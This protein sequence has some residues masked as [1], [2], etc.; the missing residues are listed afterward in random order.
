MVWV[1]G[2]IQVY[3]VLDLI[4]AKFCPVKQTGWRPMQC[5]LLRSLVWY[6]SYQCSVD[7]VNTDL[8]GISSCFGCSHLKSTLHTVPEED[9]EPHETEGQSEFLQIHLAKLHCGLF[10]FLLLLF[11]LFGYLFVFLPSQSIKCPISKGQ[12]SKSKGLWQNCSTVVQVWLKKKKKKVVGLT[13]MFCE[14]NLN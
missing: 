11:C 3:S 6:R 14:A 9:G 5:F 7:R 1:W 13:I 8:E 2:V 4:M 10:L 12:R